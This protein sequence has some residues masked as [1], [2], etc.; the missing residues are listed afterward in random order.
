MKNADKA[1]KSAL[2][3]ALSNDPISCCTQFYNPIGAISGILEN[4]RLTGAEDDADAL[5]RIVIEHAEKLIK[6]T[7][8][9]IVTCKRLDGSFSYDS[10]PRSR[11]SQKAPVGLG[12]EEG[13]I[14]ASSMCSTGIVYNLCGALGI[15]RIPIFCEK[16][17][18][19]FFD[20]IDNAIHLQKK[21][22]K[23]K[24]FDDAIDQNKVRK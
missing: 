2:I 15:P 11:L 1:M 8:E 3:S 13:D 18:K 6:A 14:N 5:R 4:L 22:E 7:R 24:W 20:I 19:I 9:K 12:L 16:D 17:S 21:Y 10:Q 23:P